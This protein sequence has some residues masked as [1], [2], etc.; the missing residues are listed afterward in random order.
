MLLIKK[1][2]IYEKFD[3][4]KKVPAVLNVQVWDNDTFSPN[5]FLGTLTIN[6]S[7][8]VKPAVTADKSSTKINSY[9]NLFVDGKVKGW[10]PLRGRENDKGVSFF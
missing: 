7:H 5:D 3:T 4:E 10:F 2:T 8:F 9:K 6:L 1:K